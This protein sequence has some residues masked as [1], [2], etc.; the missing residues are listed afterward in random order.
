MRESL[1]NKL[2]GFNFRIVSKVDNEH[3]FLHEHFL[4]YVLIQMCIKFLNLSLIKQN[5]FKI[6]RNGFISFLKMHTIKQVVKH[7]N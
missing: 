7:Q 5:A 3:Y 4:T 6:N 1:D 2:S